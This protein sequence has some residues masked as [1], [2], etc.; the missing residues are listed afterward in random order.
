M[1]NRMLRYGSSARSRLRIAWLR[2]LGAKIGKKCRLM[3]IELPRNPWDIALADNVSLDR[4]V[5]LLSTGAR[6]G[7]P[8]I[9]IGSRTYCNRW[10]F[11]DASLEISV[12]E[13]CMIG[14]SCYITD[15]DHAT[16]AG[17]PVGAQGLVS[18]PVRIG[19]DVWIG[20]GAIVLKGVALGDGAVIGA[21]AVVT[22]DVAPG[23]VVA[24]SPARALRTRA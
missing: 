15:H 24:G 1:I 12:G 20:A 10:A 19:A 23:E 21:G 2:L 22:R 5:V 7:R 18:A 6:T 8:R 13:N 11:F 9:T 3:A 4:G 16:A 14:P 17:R